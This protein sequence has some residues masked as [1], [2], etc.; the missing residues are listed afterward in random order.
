[1]SSLTSGISATPSL[2]QFLEES[3]NGQHGD[4]SVL[5]VQIRGVDLVETA[6]KRGPANGDLSQLEEYLG[7]DP[8]FFLLRANASKWYLI[9]WMPEGKVG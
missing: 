9:T 7:N 3:Q 1:M 5:R 2:K 6:R 4:I 8:A